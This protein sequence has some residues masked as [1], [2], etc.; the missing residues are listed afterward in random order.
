MKALAKRR[1]HRFA[2]IVVLF[3]SL[4]AIG[5]VYAA[6]SPETQ[7][8]SSPSSSDVE[9]GEKLFVMNCASCHG[10]DAVGTDNG[11]SLQG[12]GAASVD[13][14]VG[15]GRMP[16][17]MS[18]PQAAVKPVMFTDEQVSQLAA[19]VA[20]LGPGPAIPDADMVDPEAGDPA[21]GM[22]VFRTNCAMCHGAVGNGGALTHG[23]YAPSLREVDPTHI[24]EAMRV[25]PQNMPIFNEANI[26]DEEARDVI[27]FLKFHDQGT[28]GGL[29]IGGVGPVAEGMWIWILGI[30]GLIA[31]SVWIG[32]K[33]S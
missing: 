2:P 18:G 7:A 31:I 24:Y 16:M 10:M 9:M 12:V 4:L 13:F 27:A 14:Q 17:Q 23:K 11:P 21:N 19:Y 6:F 22:A 25:G 20:T 5:S 15:T 32:A 33:S 1:H 8:A 30:G 28:A 29:E 3:L 26:T